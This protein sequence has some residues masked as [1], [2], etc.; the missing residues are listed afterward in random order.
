MDGVIRLY[1]S[2]AVWTEETQDV[3]KFYINTEG[4][5]NEGNACD[6]SQSSTGY[7]DTTS[8]KYYHCVG[9]YKTEIF[10]AEKP[11]G[12]FLHKRVAIT[13]DDNGGSSGNQTQTRTWQE[14]QITAPSNPTRSGYIFDGW[15]TAASGG[16]QISF[17]YTTPSNDVTFY[18]MWSLN[19]PTNATITQY[20]NTSSSIKVKISNPNNYQV[21]VY[22]ALND[23]QADDYSVLLSAGT[24]AYHNFTGIGGG[25]Y[26]YYRTVRVSDNQETSVDSKYIYTSYPYEW[27]FIAEYSESQSFPFDFDDSVPNSSSYNSQSEIKAWLNANYDPDNYKNQVIEVSVP[28]NQV[29]QYWE[30]MET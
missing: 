23:S 29:F 10:D 3:G 2:D 26:F 13:F 15:S 5:T 28:Y 24:Y 19:L 7:H 22:F 18:A 4:F 8:G 17:P 6:M 20:S 25:Y 14:E 27:V 30:S 16:S 21:R 12:T 1:R 11:D 9:T